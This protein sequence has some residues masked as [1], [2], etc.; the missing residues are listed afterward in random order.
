MNRGAASV[1][2]EVLLLSGMKPHDPDQN[3]GEGDRRSA[4]LYN[5]DV[6]RF[7]ADGKVEEAA[8]EAREFVER[9]PS[10]AARAEAKARRGPRGP[11]ATVDELIAKG[12]TIVDR[13][14]PLIDRV[15]SRVRRRF[16]R[17]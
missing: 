12:R 11:R 17:R 15:A 14:R 8:R 9:D 16:R 5:R 2:R 13:V 4:R 3:Q 6:R 10:G 7:V 1:A